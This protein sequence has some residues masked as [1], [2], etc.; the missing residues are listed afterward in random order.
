MSAPEPLDLSCAEDE[1]DCLI[2][3]KLS[4]GALRVTMC[5]EQGLCIY[6]SAADARRLR[7]WLTEALGDES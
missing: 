2:V 3:E 1:Q 7:D 6:L 4:V 5:Q